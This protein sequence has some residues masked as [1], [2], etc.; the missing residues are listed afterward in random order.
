ME[1]EVS[2]IDFINKIIQIF[3]QDLKQVRI[4]T[5]EAGLIKLIKL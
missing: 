4:S 2:V 3:K 5:Q 1:E